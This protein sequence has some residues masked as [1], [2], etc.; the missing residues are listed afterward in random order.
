[1]VK[2]LL[3]IIG[4]I[5][6]LSSCGGDVA[7]QIEGKLK[8]LEDQTVYAVFE[9]DDVKV[10]DTITCEKPGQFLIKRRDGDFKELTLFIENKSEWF[11]VYLEK[12]EKV[13]ITGDATYPSLL[14]IKGGRINDQLTS[15]KKEIASLLKE[16]TD[17]I[18]ILNKDSK[19]SLDHS[20]EDTDVAARL[21]NVNHQLEERSM[22]YIKD[23]PNEEASVVLISK[24]F[25]NPDDTREL[26]ELLAIL[27]P[28]LKDFYLVKKLEEYS[29]RAKRTE[30]GAEAPNFNVKNVFGTPISLDSFPEKY[31]LLTF[32]APWCDICQTEN[33]QLNEIATKYP[34]DKLAMLLVSLDDNPKD[35]R[36]LLAKD[37]IAWNLV[38][39]SAGQAAMLLSLYNVSALPRC[40]VIDREGKIVLKTDNGV[41]VK[42]TLENLME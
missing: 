25:T 26:D 22:S 17:L 3:L 18:R 36:T 37:S 23:Y 5:V 34:K 12:G 16:H 21:A 9:N 32:T 8:N 31:L 19:D 29:A 7:Y 27:S 11:T 14:Q 20:I 40:Y 10:V 35:V 2:R 42:Q 28:D 13:S 15:M 4:I 6:S 1:M 38:T 30:L 33:L 41:E 24:F 39:D